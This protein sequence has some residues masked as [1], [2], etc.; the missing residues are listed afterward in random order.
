MSDA[1]GRFFYPGPTE[2]R[3]EVLAAMQRPMI[4][5][6]GRAFEELY[7]R[8]QSGLRALFRTTRPVYVVTSSA[9]GLMESAIR[10]APAGAIF[11]IDHGAF[12]GR[13]GDIARACG[14]EVEVHSTP[15][16]EAPDVHEIEQRL[17]SRR[18]AAVTVVH[19]ETSTGVTTDIRRITELAHSAGAEV[20]VDSVT[21]I[22]GIPL[23]FDAWDLDFAFTGSQK[24]LALPPGLALAAADEQFV[25]TAR[26]VGERG[27]YFDVV[28]FDEYAKKNQTP[29]TPV[30]SL[31]Y[32]LDVQLTA[33]ASEGIEARWARHAAMAHMASSWADALRAEGIDVSLLPPANARAATVSVFKLPSGVRSADIVAAVAARGFVIGTGYGQLRDTTLRVGHMGDHTPQGLAACLDAC[34]A[35][36]RGAKS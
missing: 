2:V 30:V 19:S 12:S 5:H 27:R 4:P 33:I 35:A 8:I 34:G 7:A 14:R 22:A 1:F 15:W 18:F 9:T 25:E 20:L 29:N 36:L 32:A 6:R 23:E 28:E 11:A 13:F 24:A 17:Q 21:G 26:G 16:G 3:S 31:L 10:C